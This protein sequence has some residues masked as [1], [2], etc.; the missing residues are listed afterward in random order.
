M[1]PWPRF[2]QPHCIERDEKVVEKECIKLAKV[3]KRVY[4]RMGEVKI[5]PHYFSVPK[6]EDIRMVYKRTSSG[7]NSSFWAPNFALPTIGSTL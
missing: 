1:G 7:S 4:V 3:G 5:F 6:G 2:L